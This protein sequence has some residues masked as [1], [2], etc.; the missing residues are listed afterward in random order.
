MKR[1]SIFFA[2]TVSANIHAGTR[3]TGGTRAGVDIAL[4]RNAKKKS[5]SVVGKFMHKLFR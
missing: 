2:Y 3:D 4:E 5:R 1:Y